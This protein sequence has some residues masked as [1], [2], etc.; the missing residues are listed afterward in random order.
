MA[1]ILLVED[2]LELRDVLENILT[3]E[4]HCV[5]CA[6]DGF[7][8]IELFIEGSWDLVVMDLLLPNKEGLETIQ[9]ILVEEPGLGILAMSGGGCGDAGSYLALAKA[10]GAKKTLTKPFT[11]SEFLG[12]VESFLAP[13]PGRTQIS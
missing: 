8:A 12:A 6:S 2:N 1:R 4:A 3:D 10:F 9:E 5:C 7:E 11:R 13:I